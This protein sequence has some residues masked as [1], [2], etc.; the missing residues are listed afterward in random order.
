MSPVK[1]F[2]LPLDGE[3]MKD[4][5]LGEVS[6]KHLNMCFIVHS[7]VQA[8]HLPRSLTFQIKDGANDPVPLFVLQFVL[9]F[10]WILKG[11]F[12]LKLLPLKVTE[13][14]SK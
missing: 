11:A 1:P 14:D 7:W 10:L 4:L 13:Q 2:Y 9:Q 3:L 8:A 6:S 12:G 5:S